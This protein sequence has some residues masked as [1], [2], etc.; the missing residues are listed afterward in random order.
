MG[1]GDYWSFVQRRLLDDDEL[2]LRSQVDQAVGADG[3]SPFSTAVM[4]VCAL[5]D[6]HR[7]RATL[8]S[9]VARRTRP[10]WGNFHQASHTLALIDRWGIGSIPEVKA[11]FPDV[12]Y[13]PLLAHVRQ[14]FQVICDTDVAAA[15]VITLVLEHRDEFWRVF[16][17]GLATP[18]EVVMDQS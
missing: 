11:G 6:P 13:I 12:G 7:Y 10:F 3:S 15:A 1:N 5:Q 8:R 16:S 17:L 2:W 4:F 14:S 18:P 9:L